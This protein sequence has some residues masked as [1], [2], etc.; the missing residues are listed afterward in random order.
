MNCLAENMGF[1]D[2]RVMCVRFLALLAIVWVATACAIQPRVVD[3][4]FE[5]DALRD[6]PNVEVLDYR[7]G[8]SKLPG[9]APDEMEYKRK[10][11]GQRTGVSGPMLVGEFLYVKW[12]IRSTD[13]AYEKTIDLRNRLPRNIEDHTIYFVIKG[14]Q[15]FIYLISPEHIERGAP[16]SDLRKYRDRKYAIIYPDQPKN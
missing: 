6:S 3:H 7:Y 13:V 5:F 15:P 12:R 2:W 11:I 9:I 16:L 10:S 8:N 1:R 4:S 14:D